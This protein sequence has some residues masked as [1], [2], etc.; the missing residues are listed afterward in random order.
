[1]S[2]IN[3]ILYLS[4]LLLTFKFPDITKGVIFELLPFNDRIEIFEL[5]GKD[6]LKALERSFSGAWNINPFKGPYVLQLS[7]KTINKMVSLYL[8]FISF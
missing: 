8:L 7:G 6:I 3:F 5:Q 1:M 4:L 2:C